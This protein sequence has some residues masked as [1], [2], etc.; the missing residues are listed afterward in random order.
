MARCVC[1]CVWTYLARESSCPLALGFST[2]SRLTSIMSIRKERVVYTSPLSTVCQAH[3]RA[4]THTQMDGQTGYN[5]SCTEEASLLAWR[6]AVL[7]L[8]G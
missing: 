4:R 5:H 3:T 7:W 2:S 6:S 8:T 1:V